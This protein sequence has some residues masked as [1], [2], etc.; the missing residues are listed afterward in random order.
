M[1]AV[2]I[3]GV[4]ATIAISSYQ[5]RIRKSHLTSLYQELS[6][7]RMPYQI[8]VDEGAGVTKFSPSGL[9]MYSQTKYCQFTVALHNNNGTTLNAVRCQ[10]QNLSYLNNQ[11][12]SLDLAADGKWQCRASTGI[13]A[14]Y[15]PEAC[16]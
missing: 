1:I 6:Q 16:R 15:L 7:F 11:T 5:I 13:P 14:H 2:A 12:L 9:N 8:L 4:L 10:I 3:V